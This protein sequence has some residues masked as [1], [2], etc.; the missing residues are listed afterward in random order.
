MN[1]KKQ[2]IVY[3]TAQWCQ[4]CKRLDLSQIKAE[5]KSLG[6]PFWI[7]VEEENNYTAGYCSVNR[8]PTFV[9]FEPKNIKCKISNSKTEA[10]VEWLRKQ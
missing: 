4:A 2:W 10:V 6:I 7:C 8:Y 1:E 9:F 3:F 5:C